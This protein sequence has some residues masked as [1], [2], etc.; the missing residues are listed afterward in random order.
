M[1]SEKEPQSASELSNDVQPAS[2]GLRWRRRRRKEEEEEEEQLLL[3]LL[4]LQLQLQLLLQLLQL[5]LQLLQQQQQ[6]QQQLLLLLLLQLQLQLQLQL[7]LRLRLR[8]RLRLQ[9]QLPQPRII[10]LHMAFSLCAMVTSAANR[11]S[12]HRSTASS[13]AARSSGSTCERAGPLHMGT[14]SKQTTP[15]PKPV[16]G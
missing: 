15:L 8:L 9:L 14:V 7:P 1:D 13:T 4:L 12:C 2:S 5:L 11:P 10:P 3:L 6:Q 16:G